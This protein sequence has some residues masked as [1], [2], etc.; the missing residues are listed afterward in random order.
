MEKFLFWLLWRE[1][2]VVPAL[3]QY[4]SIAILNQAKYK[5]EAQASEYYGYSL[6]CASGLYCRAL[7]R[8]AIG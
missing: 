2:F 6:A 8:D 3:T 5:P 7:V 1:M 4:C